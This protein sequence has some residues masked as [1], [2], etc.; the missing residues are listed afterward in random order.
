MPFLV[1]VLGVC[2]VIS[3]CRLVCKPAS[4]VKLGGESLLVFRI[5]GH[6]L[7]PPKGGSASVHIMSGF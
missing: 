3:L 2:D 4:L 6:V 1:V 5:C 7:S